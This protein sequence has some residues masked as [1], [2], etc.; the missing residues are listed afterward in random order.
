MFVNITDIVDSLEKE[1]LLLKK[2]N[3]SLQEQ[4]TL[5][6]KAVQNVTREKHADRQTHAQ[7][8]ECSNVSLQEQ[9]TL[10]EKVVQN[11]TREK[12]ADRQTHA[13]TGSGKSIGAV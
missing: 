2:S 5:L 8:G 11:V 4:V 9:V 3:V 6:E 10:L 13:Q 1:N 12:H 7:T